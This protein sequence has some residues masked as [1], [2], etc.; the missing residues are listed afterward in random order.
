[1]KKSIP[2]EQADQ[3]RRKK[4]QV[5]FDIRFH[6]SSTTEGQERKRKQKKIRNKWLGVSRYESLRT[7]PVYSN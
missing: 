4:K 2:S 6:S 1:M 7:P 3:D 5:V